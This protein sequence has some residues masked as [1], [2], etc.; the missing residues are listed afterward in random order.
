MEGQWKDLNDTLDDRA[1]SGKER[2]EQLIAYEQLRDKVIQWLTTTENNLDNILPV[3]LEMDI[4]KKQFEELKVIKYLKV[5][6]IFFIMF[7]YIIV[8]IFNFN[9]QIELMCNILISFCSL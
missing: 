4:V 8:L 1:R 3:G 9:N 5:A 6:F 2:S 7:V